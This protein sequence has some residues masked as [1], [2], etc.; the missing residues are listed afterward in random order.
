[1]LFTRDNKFNRSLLA[2]TLKFGTANNGEIIMRVN[3]DYLKAHQYKTADNFKTRV[4]LHRH[5]TNKEPF[6]PWVRDKYPILAGAKI[7]EV[8]CGLGTFWQE[9]INTLPKD[10][11]I[12]L[13]DFSEGMLTTTRETLAPLNQPQIHF[14]TADVEHLPYSSKSFDVVLAHFM[15][16]HA[17]SPTK[18]LGEIKR[19][20]KDS[21]GF[22]GIVL[23]S[24]ENMQKLFDLLGCENPTQARNFSAEMALEVLP[25]FFTNIQQYIHRN[26]LKL[27]EVELI[28]NYVRSLST[29]AEKPKEFYETNRK[30]LAEI[31]AKEGCLS[32]PT[33]QYV[34][35]V[36]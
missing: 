25:K 19:V 1:M 13:T 14:E 21:G 5:G 36:S 12:L 32:L 2:N 10:C 15:L 9:V 8:G 17:D 7:L 23:P 34:F 35:V 28:I 30:I 26:T 33:Q 22:V 16:Y 11:D 24:G 20:L 4:N 18:A 27:T 31:I 6:W 3:K 29:M